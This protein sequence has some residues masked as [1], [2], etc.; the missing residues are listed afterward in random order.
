MLCPFTIDPSLPRNSR[1][2]RT[3]SPS[4]FTANQ[5]AHTTRADI[6]PAVHYKLVPALARTLQISGIGI[7]VTSRWSLQI[8]GSGGMYITN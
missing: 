3:H 6:I 8:G 5:P 1:T 2:S 4:P 7:D